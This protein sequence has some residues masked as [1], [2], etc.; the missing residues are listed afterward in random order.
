MDNWVLAIVGF[1]IAIFSS[2]IG[3]GG[4][5]LWAPFFILIKGF[6][7]GMAILFSFTVQI[8]GMGAASFSNYRIKS[9]EWRTALGLLP[10]ITVGVVAGGF[11][12]RM[13]P[14]RHFLEGGLGI[15]SLAESIYFTLHIEKYDEVAVFDPK[16]KSP[17]W[18][19]MLTLLFGTFSGLFSIGISDFIVPT[20]RGKLKIPMKVA[21]GTSI[22]LN[23]YSALV[24]TISS[25]AFLDYDLPPDTVSIF[26]FC[27][28]GVMMGGFFGPRIAKFLADDRMKE[29][30]IFVLLILGMHLIYQTL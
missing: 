2:M 8:F 24:G 14:N 4:G 7:F 1:F 5:L 12:F 15:L 16:Q 3:I 13:V 19:K 29:L 10:F 17:F 22:F 9:I 25:F 28:A 18:L 20:F 23:F 6:D 11:L 21:I 27:W 30:F 26:L